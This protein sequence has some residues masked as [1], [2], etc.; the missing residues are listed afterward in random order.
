M[1]IRIEVSE[2]SLENEQLNLHI[3]E[4][5]LSKTNRSKSER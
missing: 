3:E 1:V 5:Q 4:E 2:A